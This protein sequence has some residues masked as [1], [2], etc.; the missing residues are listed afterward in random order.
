MKKYFYIILSLL[1]IPMLVNAETLTYNICKSGCEYNDVTTVLNEINNATENSDIKIVF[2]DS[3]T[4]E[5]YSNQ[6]I[7]SINRHFSSFEIIGNNATI[8]NLAIEIKADDI[9]IKD[10]TISKEKTDNNSGVSV[11]ECQA[12]N[13]IVNNINIVT[14]IADT[15]NINI[16]D[17]NFIDGISGD[18]NNE[19]NINNLNAKMVLIGQDGGSTL[20]TANIENINIDLLYLEDCN[21]TIRNSKVI[22]II[23][24]YGT[25]NVYNSTGKVL[26]SNANIYGSNNTKT[27]YIKVTNEN[28]L[29][30]A[31]TNYED[32][33]L[34]NPDNWLY[35][36]TEIAIEPEIP[37]GIF[38]YY[39]LEKDV[40]VNQ[41]ID[42]LQL[43][44]TDIA[45]KEVAYT[46]NDNSIVKIE[47]NSLIGLKEGSTTIV[48]TTDDG[49]IIYTL[50]VNV[51]KETIPEKIDKMTIKVPITGSKVKAWIVVVSTILLGV[52]GVCS[53]MLIK[54]K[55]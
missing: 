54:R 50:K 27:D 33:G 14:L 18:I 12:N 34:F 47:D 43:F 42:F 38:V 51:L 31:F 37:S 2:K 13:L 22:G 24:S 41:K 30:T 52:I 39:D 46:V 4:Y 21:A 9:D 44:N 20:S 32:T 16:S 5:G 40:S 11:I 25:L 8:K 6:F 15:N 53:Y 48:G 23:S 45:E 35:T 26:A 1:L 28:Q 29:S 10:L 17:S 3:D 36:Y 55:K 49:H 19:I 7:Y